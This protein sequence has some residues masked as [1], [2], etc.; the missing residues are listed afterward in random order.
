MLFTQQGR[1]VGITA[2]ATAAGQVAEALLLAVAPVGYPVFAALFVSSG[3]LR[4]LAAARLPVA[5]SW[6]DATRVIS[7]AELGRH[8][9][10]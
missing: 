4:L 9:G 8:E 7:L 10:P 1:F 6:S 2:T 5:D 3:G